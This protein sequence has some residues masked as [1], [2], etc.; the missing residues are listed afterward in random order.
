MEDLLYDFSKGQ[1][2]PYCFSS[3]DCPKFSPPVGGLKSKMEEKIEFLNQKQK[4]DHCYFLSSLECCKTAM[5]E[6]QQC[7]FSEF[8]AS[9]EM[10]SGVIAVAGPPAAGKSTAVLQYLSLREEQFSAA[11]TSA[12]EVHLSSA[13]SFFMYY[14]TARSSSSDVLSPMV[15]RIKEDEIRFLQQKRFQREGRVAREST[16]HRSH[17]SSTS[18]PSSFPLR[19]SPP[20]AAGRKRCRLETVSLEFSAAVVSWLHTH[21]RGSELH[22]VLDDADYVKQESASINS[23]LDGC[24]LSLS[25]KS[26]PKCDRDD[27]EGWNGESAV[28]LW[29]ISQIPRRLPN[30]FRFHFFKPPTT[31]QLM[32][33][34]ADDYEASSFTA[35]SWKDARWKHTSNNKGDSSVKCRVHTHLGESSSAD[36]CKKMAT[37]YVSKAVEYYHSH[38]PMS[39][40]LVTHD[41]RLL[42]QRI[43]VLLPGLFHR[44]HREEEIR[45]STLPQ[46]HFKNVVEE[47]SKSESS[48]GGFSCA[49]SS[50]SPF[51]ASGS[52]SG[53]NDHPSYPVGEDNTIGPSPISS[54]PNGGDSLSCR[55][56]A[57]HWAK[58]WRATATY[59]SLYE[60][61][62]EKEKRK[63]DTAEGEPTSQASTFSAL[64]TMSNAKEDALSLAF[65]R[66]GFT[67]VLLALSAFYCG[68]VPL[69]QQKRALFTSH[70]EKSSKKNKGI[71]ASSVPKTVSNVLVSSTFAFSVSQLAQ[72]YRALLPLCTV[73][74]DSL[75][76][77]SPSWACTNIF[78]RLVSCGLCSPSRSVGSSI[79]SGAGSYHCWIPSSTAMRLGELMGINMNELLPL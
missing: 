18:R 54:S 76:F 55:A 21:E 27:S 62:D 37:C 14:G 75:E 72:V 69:V 4:N 68:A 42:L 67:T 5:E 41:I 29:I 53:T 38:Q 63:A 30:C 64:A 16:S 74:V 3:I 34:A 32:Q 59:S 15:S 43:Y 60:I 44:L 25:F 47:N 70:L 7:I 71:T 56:N 26:A 48:L 6:N 65:L 36:V 79:A 40:S 22:L 17:N 23:W 24:F 58:A 10:G 77:A 61:V 13:P 51:I 9:I 39:S 45:L 2:D 33:W 20:V 46:E 66:M 35:N 8:D 57:L 28:F 52:E 73:R 31:R 49:S 11:F 78:P 50:A 19:L 12:R 1:Q